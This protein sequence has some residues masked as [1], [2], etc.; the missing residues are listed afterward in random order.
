M[1]PIA[2]EIRGYAAVITKLYAV[3]AD[4]SPFRRLPSPGTPDTEPEDQ[5][6]V[7][8]EFP[9][10]VAAGNSYN[11]SAIGCH[12]P[13]RTYTREE[14]IAAV[15]LAGSAQLLQTIHTQIERQKGEAKAVERKAKVEGVVKEVESMLDLE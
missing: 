6:L 5:L 4:T 9:M 10:P 1:K 12:I 2:E 14:F 8:I 7:I 13:A 11:I 3:P 15:V